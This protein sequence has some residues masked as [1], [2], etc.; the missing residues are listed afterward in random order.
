MVEKSG[1]LEG[2]FPPG[3]A[4]FWFRLSCAFSLL[5]GLGWGLRTYISNGIPGAAAAAAAAAV[6]GKPTLTTT[7][8]APKA[9][10]ALQSCIMSSKLSCGVWLSCLFLETWQ[11]DS[12]GKPT[13]VGER[14]PSLAEQDGITDMDP[15]W[16]RAPGGGSEFAGP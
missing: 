10:S 5:E 16:G 6:P 14:G 1:C 9:C 4:V 8:M 15:S 7:G 2:A 12:W 3:P 11:E 13:Q